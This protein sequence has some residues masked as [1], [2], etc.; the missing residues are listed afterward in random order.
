ME[1]KVEG[2]TIVGFIDEKPPVEKTPKAENAPK[3]RTRKTKGE[4]A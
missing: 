2:G 3:K 1:R 4:S